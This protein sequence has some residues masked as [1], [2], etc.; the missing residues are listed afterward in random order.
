STTVTDEEPDDSQSLVQGT[1]SQ[2]VV[3]GAAPLVAGSPVAV[4]ATE[5]EEF[6]G[7]VAL[8]STSDPNSTATYVATIDWGD[9]TRSAGT[10]TE[11]SGQE[12]VAGDHTYAQAGHYSISVLIQDS[13]GATLIETTTPTVAAAQITPHR[14]ALRA[15]VQQSTGQVSVAGFS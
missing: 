3:I 13:D 5:G 9:G 15:L 8:F 14:E 2:Q 11:Q 12:V 6:D 7:P 10:V 1:I 4:V